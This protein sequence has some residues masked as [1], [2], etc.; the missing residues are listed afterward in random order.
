[1]IFSAS[2]KRKVRLAERKMAKILM[3]ICYVERWQWIK[4]KFDVVYVCKCL[5]FRAQHMFLV[6]CNI[7]HLKA[8]NN[9]YRVLHKKPVILQLS[10]FSKIQEICDKMCRVSRLIRSNRILTKAKSSAATAAA[11]ATTTATKKTHRRN[12]QKYLCHFG[13]KSLAYRNSQSLNHSHTHILRHPTGEML[14]TEWDE[15]CQRHTRNFFHT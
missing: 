10:S 4:I 15:E 2:N 6:K 9:T 11:R 3:R 12:E 7:V 5:C 13:H 14:P 8:A 1:M